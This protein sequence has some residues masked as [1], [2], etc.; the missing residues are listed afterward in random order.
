DPGG[1][2]TETSA[3]GAFTAGTGV[4]NTDGLAAGVY[5]FTYTVSAVAPCLD[6]VADFTVTVE[7]EANAGPDNSTSVCNTAGS[8]TDCNTL[9]SGADPGGTWAETTGSGAFN[10]A[11]AVLNT[12]GLAAGTYTFTYTVT[13][14]AP[15]LPDVAT[16]TITVSQEA[17]AGP[18]NSISVCNT[19]G[20][21]VDCNSLLSG[22]DP[23]G[24]WAE[25]SASGAFNPATGVLNT[26][27]L[28]AGSYTFTYTVTPAA[29]CLPDVSDFTVTVEQEVFA[30]TDGSASICNLTGS[31]VDLNTLLSGA[32]PG[33]AWAETSASGAFTAGTG[34]LNTDGLAVGVYTF[35]YTV[36][37]VAPC[38]DDV[39]D[40]TVTIE[41]EAI[42][43]PD[44]LGTICNS[45]G[46][47]IDVNTLL[48]GAAPGIWAET[49]ASGQFTPGTGIF[50]ASGL[51]TG[52]YTF[53]YTVT[54]VAPCVDDVANISITVTILPTAGL[55]N[56]TSI[57]NISGS[58]VDINTLLSGADPGGIWAETTGSGAFDT[59]TG[60]LNTDGL[61]LGIYSFTYD[62]LPSGPCPGD[63]SIFTITV[64][65]EVLAGT[66]STSALCNFAGS[67]I[68]LNTILDA[69][70]TAGGTWTETSASGAFTAG[71]G[72][73]NTDGLAAG[74][75]TFTYQVLGVAPCPN[76]LANFTI[77]VEQ[78]V[79]AGI[80]NGTTTCNVGG[81]IIDVT[82]LLDPLA[83]AG[84]TWAET[85]ASGTFNPA[86]G[87]FDVS[88]LTG[89]VYT[90]T[91]TMTATSPCP[92]D[93]AN[94]TVT[95]NEAPVIGPLPNEEVCDQDNLVSQTFTANIPGTLFDWT[96]LTGTDV[97]FGLLGNNVTSIGS[98]LGN[99]SGSTVDVTVTVEV[100]P[101]AAG[102][103]GLP[104]TFNITI[105][106]LPQLGFTP[107]I[108]KGCFPMQVQFLND[109]PGEPAATCL[110][111]FGD[112]TTSTD[113]DL[114]NHTYTM[115]G[116]YDVGLTVTTAFG[117]SR[118]LSV[119]NLIEV[120]PQAVAA[121]TYKPNP[122]TVDDPTVYFE[123]QSI[124]AIGYKWD[125]GDFSYNSSEINPIHIYP[126]IGNKKYEVR[127]TAYSAGGCDDQAIQIIMI[128]DIIL[129]FIPNVFTPDGNQYNNEFKPVITAGVDIYDY[130]LMIFNRWGE[131]VMESYNMDY[132]WDGTYAS[133]G[134]VQD[135]VYVWTLEFGETMSDKRHRHMGHVTV[136]K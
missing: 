129:F 48:S 8:S 109:Y 87:L 17:D 74:V 42:A 2:W 124:N 34:I 76:D 46:S 106:P 66:D 57:C 68:N 88:G 113:C 41:Q 128:K 121:F 110:W 122:I 127:L 4:L 134:L 85:S 69:T 21:S 27:G 59:A 10:A 31:T 38:L 130:H 115:E 51:A 30:G 20:S 117:C 33:G 73:L 133:R 111:T 91:Y 9:L 5:T 50:D 52:V 95:V 12:D 32:D 53:T 47:T 28:A 7:Q 103:V 126:Q 54:G 132:G 67:S 107:D 35:T 56:S 11:T 22:A 101:E 79:F 116:F 25:T 83:D 93:V 1:T 84:G 97:G 135:G 75:Y 71:T 89:G 58:T 14:I 6:D 112:G 80:D 29:P 94:F 13:P 43:G 99:S 44:N 60:I 119:S 24:T 49:S 120:Y 62:I 63:Q 125:F 40:F 37:A 90:F 114:V 65:Q 26:D 18:D 16:F 92:D 100:T 23:G 118:S 45:G 15:C 77:A 39:A 78:E 3:S 108:T 81:T 98:F 96:N 61:A 82:L 136:L 55:D 86:T 70:A 104:G 102:C 123:N 131:I 19:A 64:E 105:H 72:V 36:S